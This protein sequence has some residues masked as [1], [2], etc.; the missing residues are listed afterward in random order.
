MGLD[1]RCLWASPDG[2]RG[3][4]SDGPG[5]PLLATGSSRCWCVCHGTFLKKRLKKI[6]FEKGVPIG[7]KSK[8]GYL[9][10]VDRAGGVG[11][12]TSRPTSG[13]EVPKLIPEG[14]FANKKLFLFVKSSL[15][16]LRGRPAHPT[17][18]RSPRDI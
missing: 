3:L 16:R 2:L 11:P 13:R 17:G 6:K 8:N 15:T 4:Y 7:K 9:L 10:S 5:W 1:T 14:L 12:G 18:G